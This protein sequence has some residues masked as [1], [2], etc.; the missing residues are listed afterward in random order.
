MALAK[1]APMAK[2]FRPSRRRNNLL[3]LFTLALIYFFILY[4]FLLPPRLTLE[5]E[6]LRSWFLHDS[7]DSYSSATI[8]HR[9][10]SRIL[11]V[12]SLFILSKSKHSKEEYQDWL[13]R[14]LRPITTEVYFYTSPDIASTVQAAR[15]KGLPITIDA[16]YNTPFDVPPLKGQEGWYNKMHSIDREN[17]YHSPELYSVWNAKPFFV[18]NAIRVMA[19]K[20]KTYDYVFWSDGGSFREINVYKNWPD[21]NRLDEVWH[22]GSRLSGTKAQDLLFFGIQYPPYGARDWKEDMGPIDIDF[23]EGKQWGLF[24]KL[25]SNDFNSARFIFWWFPE[26]NCLVG[27]YILRLSRL[28]QQQKHVRRERSDRLQC[29]PRSIQ[30]TY[31]YRMGERPRGACCNYWTRFRILEILV[32]ELHSRIMR[33]RMVLL[34]ILAFRSADT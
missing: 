34:S 8:P 6:F 21:P 17:S 25:K 18:D 14:F 2:V 28:L 5:D 33:T 4:E 29:P 22:E 12:S 15:G 32:P 7:D 10:S 11:L 31:H 9:N 27:A 1:L 20:G 3:I 24:K 30:R 13:Q 26:Y 23:S 19:S 16:N